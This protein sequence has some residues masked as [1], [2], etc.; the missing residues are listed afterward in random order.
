MDSIK[1]S[2]NADLRCILC[3]LS[4]QTWQRS[5]CWLF[6][7]PWCLCNVTVM[8]LFCTTLYGRGQ[9]IVDY[10][11]KVFRHWLW[12][13]FWLLSFMPCIF[14]SRYSVDDIEHKSYFAHYKPASLT[15]K[16]F[17]LT[18][19]GKIFFSFFLIRI[20][21]TINRVIPW[22]NC[23]VQTWVA[24]ANTMSHLTHWG[25][26]THICVGNLAIITS[27]NGLSPGR[28]QVII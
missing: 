7:T 28:R 21:D 27:D 18:P 26:V 12:N 16:T 14:N 6:G 20:W 15:T 22:R 13:K 9:Y 17:Y 8:M 1:R 24:S 19:M 23:S 25:R 2:S 11:T 4:E 10:Q 3:Y 5:C